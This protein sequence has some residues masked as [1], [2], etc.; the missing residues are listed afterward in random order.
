MGEAKQR[1]QS[2]RNFCRVPKSSGY[3][4]LVVSAPIDIKGIRVG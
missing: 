4:Q 3:R 2:E 1:K